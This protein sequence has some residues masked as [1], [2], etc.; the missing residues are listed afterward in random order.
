MRKKAEISIINNAYFR[1][2]IGN[3]YKYFYETE[4][5]CNTFRLD[6]LYIYTYENII[7]PLYLSV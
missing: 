1:H 7:L 4:E 5:R 3:M 6:I 2:K